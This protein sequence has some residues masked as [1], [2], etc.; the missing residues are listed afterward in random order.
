[1]MRNVCGTFRLI[2]NAALAQKFVDATLPKP[3]LP[4]NTK[5]RPRSFTLEDA[6]RII[7]PAATE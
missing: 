4:K 2:W 6:A 3:K 5:K 7:V 1:M